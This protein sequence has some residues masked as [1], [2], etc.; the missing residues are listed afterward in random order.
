M[1]SSQLILIITA[2]ISVIALAL[3]LYEWRQVASLNR[4]RKTL[5]AGS[6]AASLEDTIRTLIGE[7]KRLE[8]SQEVHEQALSELQH[9]FRFAVQKIG[10]VRFNPF[11]DGGGNLSFSL[12][13]LDGHNTGFVVTSMHGRQQNRIYA[14]RIEQGRSEVQLTEEEVEAV[15]TANQN[16]QTKAAHH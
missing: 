16:F 9:L 3:A 4:L 2:I 5:F 13:I 11:D 6:N 14:K 8:S 1:P 10:I 7:I 12:A 15:R